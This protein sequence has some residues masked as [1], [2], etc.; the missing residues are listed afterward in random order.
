VL[1]GC[2]A[3]LYPSLYRRYVRLNMLKCMLSRLLA[4]L[5]RVSELISRPTDVHYTSVPLWKPWRDF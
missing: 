2:W 3:G 5:K 1:D 4:L